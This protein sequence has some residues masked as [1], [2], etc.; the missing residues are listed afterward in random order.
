MIK[1]IRDMGNGKWG[2]RELG[3]YKKT[4]ATVGLLS[5]LS[6]SFFFSDVL[7]LISY[8]IL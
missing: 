4:K 8:S 7:N 1:G 3:D 2:I 5:L 6:F